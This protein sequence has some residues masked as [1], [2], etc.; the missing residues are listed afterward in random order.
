MHA[1]S[2]INFAIVAVLHN[3]YTSL[4]VFGRMAP[5][6]VPTTFKYILIPSTMTTTT[7]NTSTTSTKSTTTAVTPSPPSPPPPQQ[8]QQQWHCQCQ[9]HYQHNSSGDHTPPTPPQPQPQHHHHHQCHYHHN[10][11]G[12]GTPPTPP[13]ILMHQQQH[14]H[15]PITLS[16]MVH[17]KLSP[18]SSVSD[19]CPFV[20][21]SCSFNYH[22]SPISPYTRLPSFNGSFCLCFISL[23]HYY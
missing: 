1:K 21:H 3:H 13:P 6:N 5:Y 22:Y 9:C 20:N 23:S 19:F 16:H 18:T 8:Q 7:T 17:T 10:D 2:H 11:S 4:V 14:L 15:R 12:D